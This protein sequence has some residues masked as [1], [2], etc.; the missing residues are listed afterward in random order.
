M[1]NG[2][3]SFSNMGETTWFKFA[4]LIK[5]LAGITPVN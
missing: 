5:K 4:E 1:G 3:L 2:I